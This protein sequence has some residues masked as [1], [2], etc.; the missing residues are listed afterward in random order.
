MLRS[1]SAAFR[2]NGTVLV[3]LANALFERNSAGQYSNLADAETA[4]DC[5]DRP[6]LAAVAGQLAFGRCGRR[7]GRAGVRLC[8]HVGQPALRVL[9]GAVLS[10]AAH[11]ERG[12][13]WSAGAGA[14]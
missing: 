9:A 10:G 3:E 4:V 2:G 8:D 11:A 1:A 6:S 14:R 7:P 5:L 12:G 13:P